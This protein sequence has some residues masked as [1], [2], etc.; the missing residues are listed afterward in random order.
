MKTTDYKK[1]TPDKNTCAKFTQS[2]AI[3]TYLY[4]NEYLHEVLS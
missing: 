2:M 3:E 1:T 4:T